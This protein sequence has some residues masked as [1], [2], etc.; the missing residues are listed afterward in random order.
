MAEFLPDCNWYDCM[1]DR[2]NSRNLCRKCL[3]AYCNIREFALTMREGKTRE[4]LDSWLQMPKRTLIQ[5]VRKECLIQPQCREVWESILAADVEK[6]ALFI[7]RHGYIG[8]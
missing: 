6:N 2:R 3:N 7:V 4:E 8:F 5:M 1:Q